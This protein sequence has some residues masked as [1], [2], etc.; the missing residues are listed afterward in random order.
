MQI[1]TLDLDFQ[2][3]PR[4]VAAYL[5]D[6]PGGPVLIECGPGS[7]IA[8]LTAALA[9]HGCAPRDV[10]HVLVTHIHL[11][12]AGAAG[13]WAAHGARIYVHAAG[14]PHL[15][16]P[17]R[18]LA[19]AA[20]IYGDAM[21][22]LWGAMLPVPPDQLVPLADGTVVDAAGLEITA[23]DAPGHAGHHLVYRIGAIA[24]TGDAAGV[25]LPGETLIALPAP[26]PEFDREAWDRTLDR[27][28]GL[29]LRTLYPTHFGPC[30]DAAGH[31]A[32][33]RET[34]H[35]A[36]DFI[37]DG[38]TAGLERDDLVRDYTAWSL[39][40]ARALG[41]SDAAWAAYELANPLFMSVDG[42]ARYW[43][44]QIGV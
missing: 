6:A 26:P 35:A 40:R 1:H 10:R 11:D 44:K 42:I 4:A 27:L 18:L 29:D 37:R 32:A 2:G 33:L 12:H 7:T 13:W 15:A 17:S 25:R 23:I 24:F 34:L 20:R 30:G 43:R 19:S 8:A 36:T 22:R 21:E 16:D 3:T 9:D 14:A 28:A 38:M 5:V 31:L 41:V 39:A